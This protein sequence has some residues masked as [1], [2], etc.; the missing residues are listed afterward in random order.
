LRETW[1][2]I[3]DQIG[4]NEWVPGERFS[5]VDISVGLAFDSS[6]RHQFQAPYTG[7]FFFLITVSNN[8]I[9]LYLGPGIFDLRNRV[10]ATALE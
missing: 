6:C 10:L 5:S 9:V 2:V 7:T 8:L 3:D 1:K 4:D